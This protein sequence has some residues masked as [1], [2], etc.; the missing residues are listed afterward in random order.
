MPVFQRV[1]F[2]R[3]RTDLCS[4]GSEASKYDQKN[5][6][7]AFILWYDFALRGLLKA[8]GEI[9]T[10]A[11]ITN[12]IIFWPDG[13]RHR[14]KNW[15]MEQL[16]LGKA[17]QRF[18]FVGGGEQYLGNSLETRAWKWIVMHWESY[19]WIEVTWKPLLIITSLLSGLLGV[20]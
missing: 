17:R 2:V 13:F 8:Q 18:F 7:C 4:N 19:F 9:F 12:G 3:K 10:A 1:A 20:Y 5:Q 15:I 16:F 11:T 6:S 14:C